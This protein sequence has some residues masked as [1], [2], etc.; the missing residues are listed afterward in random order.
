VSRPRRDH[1][2][3]GGFVVLVNISGAYNAI[4]KPSFRVDDLLQSIINGA[5]GMEKPDG[6][7]VL[8][9]DS[10]NPVFCLFFIG[11]GKKPL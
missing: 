3:N 11:R 9:A 5:Y 1:F 7:R 6:C 2:K 4:N 10:P 8:L